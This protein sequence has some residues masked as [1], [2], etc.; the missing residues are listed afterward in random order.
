MELLRISASL[1]QEIVDES[2]DVRRE[3]Q[4]VIKARAAVSLAPATKTILES[5]STRRAEDLG[6][7]QGQ[8]L[9]LIDLNRCTRCGDCVEACI[10]T[11]DDGYSRLYLDGPRYGNYLVPSSC[12]NCRDPVC[13]IGCPVGSIQQGD[14]GEVLIR[15]WCI[16]CG[17]CARQCPYDALQMHDQSLVPSGAPGWRWTSSHANVGENWAQQ[18][19][20]DRSWRVG[21]TPVSTGIALELVAQQEQQSSDFVLPQRY[22]FRYW[23]SID[24][25]QL[26]SSRNFR[27]LLTAHGGDAE[28]FVDGKSLELSQDKRQEKKGVFQAVIPPE[29]LPGGRHLLAASARASSEAGGVVFD[30]QLDQFP[31]EEGETEEKLVSERA[32]VCDQCSS[33]SGDRHACVYACPHEAAMRIDGWADLPSA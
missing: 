21:A 18:K 6:L 2:P 3:M 23:V 5:T 20:A 14:Q 1:F 11:H 7:L 25:A 4:R 10:N 26:T 16:G 28:A 17:V 15:D 29:L 33:L 30:A 9:M 12:R 27:L 22:Y 32:V 13:M 8:K 19:F 31:L 24:P